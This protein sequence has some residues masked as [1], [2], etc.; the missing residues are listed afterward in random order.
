MEKTMSAPALPL[1]AD[2]L[3]HT[4]P[5][6]NVQILPA[7]DSLL[8]AFEAGNFLLRKFQAGLL[9]AVWSFTPAGGWR[10]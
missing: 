3:P 1:P 2:L 7:Y 5:G 9:I 6:R 10:S 8:G 4:H